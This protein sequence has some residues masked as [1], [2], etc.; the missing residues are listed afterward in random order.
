MSLGASLLPGSGE[1]DRDG[2][3]EVSRVMGGD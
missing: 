2:R 1:D 3:E